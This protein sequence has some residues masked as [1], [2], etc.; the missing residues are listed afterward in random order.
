MSAYQ[1]PPQTPRPADAA[2][3]SIPLSRLIQVELRKSVNTIASFWLVM[4][5]AIAMIMMDGFFVILGLT[6]GGDGFTFTQPFTISAAYVLQPALAVLA[7]MLVTSE[8]GQRTAMVTFSLEPR[9][10]RVLYAKL[11]SAMGLAAAI[12]TIVLVA[13]VLCMGLLALT[14]D[15]VIWDFGIGDLAG[16]IVFEMLAVAMGYALATLIINT[17]AAIAAF[18][19]VVYVV[20]FGIAIVG[21][22][23]ADFG[24]FGPWINVQSALRP[25]IDWSLDSGD[26]WGHL[27]V[28]LI[29]WVVVPLV[30]GQI[31]ILKAEVK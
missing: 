7:I 31:R 23:W 24:D 16:L 28:T 2:S 18:P 30:L 1:A 14:G 9:R 19:V 25:I 13:A 10:Q 20:P 12:V 29:V 22:L 8:W 5:I 4:A 11:I 6:S 27:V 3:A 21:A 26:E 17:P 15:D